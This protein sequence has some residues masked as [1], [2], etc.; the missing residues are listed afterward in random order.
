MSVHHVHALLVEARRGHQHPGLELQNAVSCSVMLE[1]KP[2]LLEDG[3]VRSCET[4]LQPPLCSC[5]FS[6]MKPRQLVCV[7]LS[8]TGQ[9]LS[10]PMFGRVT[11]HVHLE[12]WGQLLGIFLFCSPFCF[13][14]EKWSLTKTKTHIWLEWLVSELQGFVCLFVFLVSQWRDFRCIPGWWECGCSE[15]EI[16]SRACKVSISHS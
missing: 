12:G 8:S 3:P 14:F 11:T 1:I 15:S 13:V 16:R 6:I 7:S 10:V 5:D 4:S 2:G 9:G